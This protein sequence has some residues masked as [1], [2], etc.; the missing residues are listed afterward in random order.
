VKDK[1]SSQLSMLSLVF[2]PISN[3]SVSAAAKKEEI[4]EIMRDS[5]FYMIGGRAAATI[6]AIQFDDDH[7]VL[8]FEIAVN[9]GPRDRGFIRLDHIPLNSTDRKHVAF[10][11]KQTK[12]FI[13][14]FL[15]HEDESLTA[16]AALD[17]EEVL[18][19]RGRNEHVIGGLKNYRELATYDLLY[20]GIAKTGDSFDRLIDNGHQARTQILSDEPQR[21][22]GA[23]VSEEI[24]IFLFKAEPIIVQTFGGDSEIEDGDLILNYSNK[25][26]VADAEKAFVSILKPKYNNILYKK[27]PKGRDG[28]YDT[29]LDSYSYSISEGMTFRTAYGSFKG[30]REGE[31]AMS[32]DADFIFIKGNDVT[33]HISG[34]DFNIQ[35]TD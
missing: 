33:L 26:L 30:A 2:P 1:T 10:A 6:T 8:H 17:P 22:E 11:Y 12:D 16:I 5:D 7:N 19:R 32:N 29:G 34:K 20:V 4:V 14:I 23:R 18:W 13:N 35:A 3:S 27:Y 15:V 9:N 25:R 24:F 21:F 28:L 31:T